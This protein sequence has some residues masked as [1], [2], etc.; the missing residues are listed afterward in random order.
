MFGDQDL[1]ALLDD[2]LLRL[3]LEQQPH[4]PSARKRSAT[5]ADTSGSSRG[6]MRG[7]RSTCVTCAPRRAK[8]CV[9]SQ[10]IGPPPR[11]SR[12]RGS[13]RSSQTVSEVR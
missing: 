6:M 12:R 11:T 2:E 4:M 13:W 10:P 3:V 5:I 1:L 7:P 8:A 9:S